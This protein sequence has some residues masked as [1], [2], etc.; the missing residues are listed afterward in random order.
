VEA[1]TEEVPSSMGPLARL[2]T[3]SKLS[4]LLAPF[5]FTFKPDFV[6]LNSPDSLG[7]SGSDGGVSL[8]HYSKE[9]RRAFIHH[10]T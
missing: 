10:Y 7:F 3:R 9:F 4:V 8:V 6:W 5:C 1:T 2:L